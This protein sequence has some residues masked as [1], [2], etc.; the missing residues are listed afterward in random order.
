M[1]TQRSAETVGEAF[2]TVF[3]R[4]SN[5]KLGK[6]TASLEDMASEDY[7]EEDW[8]ALSDVE[9]ALDN[10]GIKLR[11]NANTYR[12][13]E[14]ILDEIAEKWDTLDETSQNSVVS[15]LAGTRQRE[16]VLTLFE[17]WDSVENFARIAEDSY[18]TAEEKMLAFSDSV[19]A[20][21]NRVTDAID[22]IALWVDGAEVMKDFYNAI[23]FAINNIGT[24]TVVV[25]G[26]IA[27]LNKDKILSSVSNGLGRVGSGT[28]RA[29]DSLSKMFGFKEKEGTE[30]GFFENA[31]D[32][33]K[34][35]FQQGAQEDYLAALQKNI[36]TLDE[37]DKARAASV[38]TLLMN[39]SELDR[40]NYYAA[41][42]NELIPEQ[43]AVEESKIVDGKAY[44][45]QLKRQTTQGYETLT[46]EETLS[47]CKKLLAQETDEQ[48]Q[49]VLQAI[50]STNNLTLTQ[51]EYSAVL[52]SL[53]N[54]QKN[55]YNSQVRAAQQ[56]YSATIG[57]G[58]KGGLGKATAKGL[59]LGIGSILSDL[60]GGYA[61]S[62]IGSAFGDTGTIIGTVLGG[63]I[64]QG[65]T[66]TLTSASFTSMIASKFATIGPIAATALGSAFA[67]IAIPILIGVGTALISW[68]QGES[69][70]AAKK[71]AEVFSEESEKYTS[72]INTLNDVGTFDKYIE[73]VDSLGRNVSLTEEEYQKWLDASNALADV[74]PELTMYTDDQGNKIVGLNGKVTELTDTINEYIDAQQRAADQALLDD[75]LFEANYKEAK[76]QY[77]SAKEQLEIAQET[78]D[79]LENTRADYYNENSLTASYKTD[80][81]SKQIQKMINAINAAEIEGVYAYYDS[82]SP[83]HFQVQGTIDQIN[84][85]FEKAK[86]TLDNNMMT[87]QEQTKEASSLMTDEVNA[88]FREMEYKSEYSDLFSDMSDDLRDSLKIVISN[89]GLD[90]SD[91]DAFREQV[92]QI[93]NDLGTYFSNSNIDISMGLNPDTSMDI[94]DFQSIRQQLLN[95][96]ISVFG[97]SVE[98]LDDQEIAI[99][100]KF[101]FIWDENTKS[102]TDAFDS[103][104]QIVN[105]G[106]TSKIEG[107]LSALNGG[108]KYVYTVNE[109][110]TAYRILN[111]AAEDALFTQEQLFSAVVR[112]DY[113]DSSLIELTNAY[114]DF[115]EF[116]DELTDSEK[117][118]FEVIKDNLD[119]W[120]TRLGEVEGDY[121]AIITKVKELGDLN[122]DNVTPD[123]FMSKYTD[124]E[125]LYSYLVNDFEGAWD[126]DMLSKVY[127]N[128]DLVPLIG[129]PD[130]MAERIKGFL[131]NA[132]NEY[133]YVWG[134][135]LAQSEEG[136]DTLLKENADLV[137][138]FAE[139]YGIDLNNFDTLKE[140]QTTIDAYTTAVIEGNWGDVLNSLAIIY[141]DDL[142]NFAGAQAQ[143]IAL[144]GAVLAQM[145]VV[146]DVSAG[147]EQAN[148]DV[149]RRAIDLNNEAYYDAY[150][151]GIESGM[152]ESE[153]RQS[154]TETLRSVRDSN[155]Q[156]AYQEISEQ[157]NQKYIQQM[158]EDNLKKVQNM[159]PDLSGIMNI[160][161]PTTGFSN[162]AS[163]DSSGSGSGSGDE[164]IES[165]KKYLEELQ[166]LQN[167]INKEWEDMVAFANN[168]DSAYYGKMRENLTAQLIEVNRLLE[169][170]DSY[171]EAGMLEESDY[172]DLLKQRIDLQVELN[173][174]DD[175]QV[176]EAIDLL[177]TQDASIISLIEA[178]K[179]LIATSDTYEEL[180]E[181]QQELN[182]L[183]EQQRELQRDVYEFERNMAEMATEYVSG[184]AYSNSRIYEAMMS[185]QKQSVEQQMES[186]LDS[187]N[188]V[189]AQ[190]MQQYSS[191]GLS[192]GEAY[193]MAYDSEEARDLIQQYWELFQEYGD[194][195]Y[196]EFEDKVNELDQMIEDVE[197]TKSEKWA[198]L[199]DI[200]PYYETLVGYI[201]LKLGQIEKALENTSNMTDEQIQDWVDQYNDA[202]QQ[203]RQAQE[204]Q[205]SDTI[206]Y[207]EEMFSALTSWVQEQID[208]LEDLKDTIDD[209]YQPLI[210]DINDYN[211]SVDR[212]NE[213]LEL[214]KNLKDSLASKERVYREGEPL[215]SI[216]MAI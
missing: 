5:V 14:T 152:S 125:D 150:N 154:A 40:N 62:Q 79:L 82:N 10:I 173:N 75:T 11:E 196:Q 90:A 163:S 197:S 195:V 29:G 66:S 186:L 114:E 92:E 144:L 171:L 185:L 139:N 43:I 69:E 110:S 96:L 155:Y 156:K 215:P 19:E 167:Q 132:E 214:Q 170:F 17:N 204:D 112:A 153:A 51:N 107:G 98:E 141:E 42:A 56:G 35:G 160:D 176:Q 210:D 48:R 71:A 58:T 34:T 25:G 151:S 24:L 21:Q 72:Y 127:G 65:V 100:E 109:L 137:A 140:A 113:A 47:L 208:S 1:I 63:G 193:N 28:I 142:A 202:I 30:K 135:V 119:S 183:L 211:D 67:P 36:K 22:A 177:E 94:N 123:D 27:I 12:D 38:A 143:K 161:V 138:Q 206:D 4:I 168:T 52:E 88:I 8:E 216:K 157:Y 73:G 122:Y 194:L 117:Q 103:L 207:Q 16:I 54:A 15:A 105:S 172:N 147:Y 205:L 87:F 115:T 20:A 78:K 118:R 50:T 74:F 189:I 178:Q 148:V 134:N 169:N 203:L 3:S 184:T 111:S 175:E 61:G 23:A 6:Y 209:E 121:E 145:G 188:T 57:E 104:Q 108:G 84:E 86:D 93:V 102:F 136:T 13:T 159:M 83:D 64:L 164:D 116:S 60:V 26:L 128:E 41:M 182:D 44:S 95:G 99:I 199:K 124:Y 46:E 32:I 146:N 129:D 80:A 198:S 18:G 97:G 31:W 187:Y 133:G 68:F 59:S 91:E 212:T 101:G 120:A 126:I 201:E 181:R 81:N 158:V 174:L 192:A 39:S 33:M 49:K 2:K 213:L 70:R 130:A 180:V 77:D 89:I 53:T 166:E 37:E 9:T 55:S 106:L 165:A 200:A 45:L 162:V 149:N 179:Q 190:K 131:D 76:E 7:N 85:A 191:E